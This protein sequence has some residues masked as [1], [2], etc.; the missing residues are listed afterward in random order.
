MAR[1]LRTSDLDLNTFPYDLNLN[2]NDS[3]STVEIDDSSTSKSGTPFI[4]ARLLNDPNTLGT[5]V[6]PTGRGHTSNH[7]KLLKNGATIDAL[8]GSTSDSG[9]YYNFPDLY[10][11]PFFSFVTTRDSVT[12]THTG[13]LIQF[14]KNSASFNTIDHEINVYSGTSVNAVYALQNSAA[15]YQTVQQ[16][17][18]SGD[19]LYIR[20]KYVDN[21]GFSTDFSNPFHF[22]IP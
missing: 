12:I 3:G 1:F 11:T 6:D 17:L 9:Y 22:V 15:D 8:L 19:K 2:V 20:A 21:K 18:V 13:T 7:Y 10:I 4:L 5:G 16:T 14:S